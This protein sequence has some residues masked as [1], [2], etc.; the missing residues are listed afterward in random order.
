MAVAK[1]SSALSIR[2]IVNAARDEQKRAGK[3]GRLLVAGR[4]AGLR[5]LADAVTD[6]RADLNRGGAGLVH[7]GKAGGADVTVRELASPSARL[8]AADDDIV[9]LAAEG[10]TREELGAAVR[11]AHGSGAGLVVAVPTSQVAD[12]AKNAFDAGAFATEVEV[13]EPTRPLADARLADAVVAAAGE[14]APALARSLEWLRHA[15]VARII[16]R[17][18]FENALVGALVIVPG[19]DMPVMTLNQVRMVL[20]IG[21]AYGNDVEPQRAPEILAVVGAGFGLRAVAHQGLKLVPAAGWA[22][23]GAVGYTGTLAL[24]RAAVLYYESGAAGMLGG[25]SV[26]LPPSLERRLPAPIAGRLRGRLGTGSAAAPTDVCI[27]A[28]EEPRERNSPHVDPT[29]GGLSPGG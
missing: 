13:F 12:A 4:G 23:K 5:E 28:P 15:A 29:Q 25:A 18:A 11:E 3:A 2:R 7:I 19:A 22:L 6:G 9:L 10:L 24:G 14:R 20:R 21:A 17:T 8:G 26:E 1:T 16:R 27:E